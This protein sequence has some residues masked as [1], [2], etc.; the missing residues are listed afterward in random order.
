MTSRIRP[1]EVARQEIPEPLRRDVRLLGEVLGRVIAESGGE[2]LLHDVERLR[3]LVIRARDDDRYERK[4]EK[5]IASWSLELAELVARAFACYFHLANLAEEHHR[6]R[7]IRERDRGAEP[8]PESIG[9]TVHQLRRRLGSKRL[10]ELVASLEVH[11]VFTAHPT[12]ARRRAVVTAIRRVGD[13]LERLDDPRISNSERLDADRRLVE[14]VDSLWRT[15]QLRALQVRPVDEVRSLMAVFDDTLFRL[16]PQLMRS[17]ENALGS[18]SEIAPFVRFGSW[19]GGDRDGNSGVDARVTAEAIAIQSEHI[20]FALEAAATRIGR[21]LTVDTDTTPASAAIRRRIAQARRSDPARIDALVTRSGD[22]PHRVFLLNVAGRIAATRTGDAALAYTSP[23]AL[24]RDLHLLRDSL[25]A[26]GAERLAFGEV[27]H[28]IWQADTFGFHLAELEV[29]QHSQVH[30]TA[31]AELRSG[32]ARSKATR[33][34]LETLDLISAIQA[35][36]GVASCSRYVVSF[37]RGAEDVA[38]VYEL[39][40]QAKGPRAPVL[41]V[42][43]LFETQADLARATAVMDKV[44]ELGPVRRRLA[45]NGRRI[46]VMLGYSDSAKE[47]GPTSATIALH[48]AQAA[49][50]A[51]AKQRRLRLILFHGRGGALGRGG[52]PA[53]RAVRAQAP[54]SV[55]GHFKVTEQGEVIFARYG[56]PAIARRHLEQVT[57]A[58]LEASTTS[59]ARADPARRFRVLA[60]SID[61]PSR[62]AY[63]ALIEAP[64]FEEWFLRVSPIEELS[65]LRIASRPARRGPGRRLENLRAIPWVFAWAQMRLNLPGWYGM[66]SGLAAAPLG[67]LRRAYAEWPLFNVMLDNTEMSLAKTDRR[68]A[69]RYLALGGRPDLTAMVMREYDLTLERV[70][71]VTGH[72]RLLEDRRVLS[73]AIELRNPYVDA[74]SHLQL[75]ALRAMRKP[76]VSKRD[77]ARAERVFQLSVNGVAAGLQ[78]TG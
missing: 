32:R 39:A 61:T 50:T 55:A 36:F 65:G 74:L 62:A 26:A 19:I 17:L 66:G 38:A 20:L 72:K 73:W 18:K 76:A 41:D 60:S 28:L 23:A 1:R 24:L 10:N 57:S 8:V 7:V 64:G 22:E 5:L 29:R 6:A 71:A 2:G 56:N 3:T 53:N 70:L 31:L 63:R 68:I 75:R 27:Q 51:W 45:A 43:P 67:E 69:E 44:L 48:D 34:I 58:V 40:A 54:G 46:E 77:R 37:A 4:A 16:V 59:A 11:P 15:A 35:R 30:E 12:E 13:Q 9:A 42:V 14:E 49:L 21:T 25:A 47:I 78:N 33:D 52:G